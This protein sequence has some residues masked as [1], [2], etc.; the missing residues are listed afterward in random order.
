[1]PLALSASPVKVEFANSMPVFFLYSASNS[2]GP[3]RLYLTYQLTKQIPY[4][5]GQFTVNELCHDIVYRSM[6]PEARRS[7]SPSTD[8]TIALR[9]GIIPGFAAVILSQPTVTNQ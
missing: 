2:H 1:M 7:L 9:S 3:A 6:T 5:I 4:A 8:F